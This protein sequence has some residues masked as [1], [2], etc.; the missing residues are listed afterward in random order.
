MGQTR[1]TDKTMKNDTKQ[2]PQ[3]FDDGACRITLSLPE[4]AALKLAKG[5]AEKDPVLLAF[6]AEFSVKDIKLV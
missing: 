1:Q 3:I 6:I 2:L 4:A 5:F